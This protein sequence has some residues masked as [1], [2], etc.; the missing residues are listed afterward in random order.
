MVRRW[1]SWNASDCGLEQGHGLGRDDVH[2]RAALRARED[3]AVDL[4]GQLGAA[5]DEAAARA[6]QRLVRRRRDDVGVREGAGVQPGRHEAGDVGHV[7]EEQR[8]VGVGD[9][10]PCARSR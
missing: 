3:G 8:V 7:D 1:S 5:E 2:E 4:P 6:A 10:R 9:A